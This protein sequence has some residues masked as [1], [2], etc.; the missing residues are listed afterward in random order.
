MNRLHHPELSDSLLVYDF[1][2]TSVQLYLGDNTNSEGFVSFENAFWLRENNDKY[3]VVYTEHLG[4]HV[5]MDS[6]VV[7]IMGHHGRYER[8]GGFLS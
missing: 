3:V 7:Q 1:P 5:F 2:S 4:Y 8:P 6:T